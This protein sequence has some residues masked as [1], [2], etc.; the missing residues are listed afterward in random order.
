MAVSISLKTAAV[1]GLMRFGCVH[2][3]GNSTSQGMDDEEDGHTTRRMTPTVS[4]PSTHRYAYFTNNAYCCKTNKEKVYTPQGKACDGSSMHADDT[5]SLCCEDD[6]HTPCQKAPCKN[7]D[8]ASSCPNDNGIQG[9]RYSHNG[10]W[11]GYAYVGYTSSVE[12][13]AT[14]CG[15]GC[16]GFSR[17]EENTHCFAYLYSMS[18]AG[19][20]KV[21]T[22]HTNV[23]YMKCFFEAKFRVGQMVLRRGRGED[24][25]IMGIGFVTSVSPL[26][27]TKSSTNPSEG[28]YE[29]DEVKEAVGLGDSVE[30]YHDGNRFQGQVVN[31]YNGLTGYQYKVNGLWY[32][33]SQVALVQKAEFHIGDKVL[34]SQ[35]GDFWSGGTVTSVNPLKVDDEEWVW[36]RKAADM[37]VGDMVN[38]IKAGYNGLGKGMIGKIIKYDGS[39]MPYQ[40]QLPE[41]EPD[42]FARDSV[43]KAFKVGQEVE[44]RNGL[45]EWKDGRVT[46]LY[47]LQVKRHGDSRP[48]AWDEVRAK[49]ASDG[50]RRLSAAHAG[51]TVLI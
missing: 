26:K 23:A 11:S 38:I 33:P 51:P 41:G 2:S 39:D 14:K 1:L 28:G 25:R 27:V 16:S 15:D 21:T 20:N 12:D 35:N 30:V 47:P 18:V 7:F 49:E 42:W 6:Q 29:W 32:E 8:Q 22:V 4:C 40:I 5:T 45:E 43:T 31:V 50:G 36:I 17:N 24:W 19:E 34:K 10:Y 44:C 9:F 37:K 46:A 48:Y 3:A 13:C